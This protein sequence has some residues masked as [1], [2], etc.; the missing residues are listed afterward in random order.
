LLHYTN[1][2]I[3]QIAYELGFKNVQGFS[4]FFKRQV[5]NSPTGFRT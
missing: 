2:D 5:G 4:R 3:S 1:K